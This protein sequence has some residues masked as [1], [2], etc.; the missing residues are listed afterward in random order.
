[1]A[2]PAKAPINNPLLPWSEAIQQPGSGQMRHARALLESRPF[3][4]RVP[5]DSVLVE[6]KI[7]TA[8]PGAGRYHFTATRDSAG[9]YA[10]IYAPVGRPFR[11]RL[12]KITGPRVKAWWFNPRD[13]RA[14]AIG[15]FA[16]AG[17]RE[18]TPPDPGE[19]T[20]WVL[21]LDDAAQNFPPP[22]APR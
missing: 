9:R 14:T 17:E 21:V 6:T 7:P 10:L 2:S 1:M 22:G 15:E 12:E 19:M 13:G 16:N 20:D 4:T 3:L 8:M 18:F 5:D 11:V